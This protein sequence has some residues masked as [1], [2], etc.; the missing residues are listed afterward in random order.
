VSTAVR[1]TS[2][3]RLGA[4]IAFSLLAHGVLALGIGFTLDDAAPLVPT[5]DVILT[6]TRSETPPEQADFLAQASQQ[7]G[8]DAEQP[9]RPREPTPAPIPQPERG[10]APVPIEASAP[11]PQPESRTAMVTTTTR[12]LRRT[13]PRII[14]SS[15]RRRRYRCRPVAR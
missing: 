8:G 6:Q 4:T 2:G 10:V 3:D 11:R 5:L 12:R 1:I 15:I 13:A 14:A 7:G 9:E